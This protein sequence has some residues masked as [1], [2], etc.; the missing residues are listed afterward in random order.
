M[1]CSRWA[2]TDS[3]ARLLQPGI[4]RAVQPGDDMR[5]GADPFVQTGKD[6]LLPPLAMH[7]VGFDHP[8]R[9][10]NA[11]AMSGQKY[12]VVPLHQPFQRGQE[13]GQLPSGGA[14]TVVFHPIT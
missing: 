13:L 10:L 2:S 6:G 9:G 4:E 5:D 11:A 3:A 7:D 1:R 12:L 8:L 14:I